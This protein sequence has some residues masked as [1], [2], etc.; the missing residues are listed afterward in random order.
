M[1]ILIFFRSSETEINK[2]CTVKWFYEIY[3]FIICVMFMINISRK[4]LILV[5]ITCHR[6]TLKWIISGQFLIH[7][8]CQDIFKHTNMES[9]STS[10]DQSISVF[11]PRI[12]L[13][14]Q[15]EPS[16][17][18]L[19]LSLPFHI[20]IQS[21]YHRV[22]YH[23]ISSAANLLPI[24]IPSRAFFSRQF[25][26]SQWPS[27]FLFLFFI[28]SSIILPSPTISSTTAYFI[29]SLHFTCSILLHI[30]V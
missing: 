29:F 1:V 22:V 11:C 14:L 2:L 23:L 4:W 27:Q 17:L 15:T 30:R 13:S 3:L 12:G 28:S 6:S 9:F 8:C 26:L 16:P 18:Y 19:L 7:Q 10:I 21:I 24:T 25:L 20:F 5:S